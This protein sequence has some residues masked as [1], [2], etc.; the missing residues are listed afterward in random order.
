LPA[1]PARH[2][3][4]RRD[5][6]LPAVIKN[7]DG[8]YSVKHISPSD[9]RGAGGSLGQQIKTLPNGTKVRIIVVD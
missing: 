6:V 4:Q 1:W 8:S 3:R 9:N 2:T 5:E 7:K